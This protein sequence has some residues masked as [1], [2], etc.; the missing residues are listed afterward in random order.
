MNKSG[1]ESK[2]PADVSGEKPASDVKS[3]EEADVKEEEQEIQEEDPELK[4]PNM[5]VDGVDMTK[6]AKLTFTF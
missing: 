6:G 1:V 5:F 3:P 2:A 4:N